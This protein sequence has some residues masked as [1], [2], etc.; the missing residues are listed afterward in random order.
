MNTRTLPR[1]VGQ[2]SP[3]FLALWWRRARGSTADT[4]LRVRPWWLGGLLLA[5]P[6]AAVISMTIGPMEI[7]TA[8][9]LSIF[10]VKLGL[11]AF[12]E[13]SHAAE[14]VIWNIRFTRVLLAI[15]VGGGL[16]M[17]GAAMQGVFRNP[18]ADPGIIGVSGGGAIGAILMIVLGPRLLSD[19]F[20]ALAGLY[21]VPLAAMAGAVAMT[22]LIYRISLVGGRV[23]LVA[24]LLVGIAINALGGALIGL[25][26]FVATDDELR[27]MTFWGLGSLARANW[28]LILPAFLFIAVPLVFLPRYARALNALLLGEEDAAHLGIEVDRVK[29]RLICLAASVVGATVALCGAIG[30]IALVAPHIIRTAI[31]PDHRFLLPAAGLLGALLLLTADMGARTVAAPA[32]LPIGILT[33]LFGA[34]VFLALLLR[35]RKGSGL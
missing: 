34:P 29:R 1:S 14:I 3:H 6:M 11:P 35:R 26:T 32:E 20:F 30:F 33:A 2:L 12:A 16:A 7:S 8:Q 22:F 9:I 23:D 27:T 18:L 10:A 24:M 5:V 13:S 31:G 25:L 4:R 21:A 28:S 17:A 19:G 15:L